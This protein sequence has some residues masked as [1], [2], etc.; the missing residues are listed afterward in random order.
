MLLARRAKGGFLGATAA[1]EQLFNVRLQ[2]VK[3]AIKAFNS[4]TTT[5]AEERR[6]YAEYTD[7]ADYAKK[8][9]TSGP[10][11]AIGP[12]LMSEQVRWYN[13]RTYALSGQTGTSNQFSI[14]VE[15][16]RLLSNIAVQEVLLNIKE[17]GPAAQPLL[18]GEV[19]APG[20][21]PPETETQAAPAGLGIDSKTLTYGA[22][23][24]A[25]L[26]LGP[27]LLKGLKL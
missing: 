15:R 6:A 3:K 23:A 17:E 11:A 19:E 7:I 5:T 22:I 10:K 20:Y 24:L 21:R 18:P 2:A 14:Q 27:K 26:M 9:F 1:E 4:I 16:D 13:D 8:I 25:A 12:G